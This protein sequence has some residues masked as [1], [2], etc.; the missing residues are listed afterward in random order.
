MQEKDPRK[1]PTT[2]SYPTL[3]NNE[4]IDGDLNE[5]DTICILAG[6]SK[7]Y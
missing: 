6:H 2:P 5:T 1:K 4:G 7:S 3:I